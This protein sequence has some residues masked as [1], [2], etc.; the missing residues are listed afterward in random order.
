MSV[1]PTQELIDIPVATASVPTTP[2]ISTAN[3][4]GGHSPIRPASIP[5]RGETRHSS[6]RSSGVQTFC[7]SFAP[8]SVESIA[9]AREVRSSQKDSPEFSCL[10]ER[11]E[12]TRLISQR[13]TTIDQ[14]QFVSKRK[15]R[16]ATGQPF[17]QG[18]IVPTEAK[19]SKLSGEIL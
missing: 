1:D 4:G 14:R 17:L 10:I 9:S 16:P 18:R 19:P 3:A 7:P 12:H 6:D 15:G 8:Y 11:N 2:S 13:S 5:C